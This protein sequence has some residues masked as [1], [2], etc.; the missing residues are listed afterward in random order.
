V[1]KEGV[2]GMVDLL[3]RTETFAV[4]STRFCC[5]LWTGRCVPWSVLDQILDATTSV[6]ANVEE[7]QGATSHREFR[8]K[9]RIALREARE[10]HFRLRVLRRAEV[11]PPDDA[12]ELEWLIDEADQLKRILGQCVVTAERNIAEAKRKA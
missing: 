10:S 3:E 2:V 9:Y 12:A 5:R 11:T 6:G 4:R 1:K 8:V 7:G